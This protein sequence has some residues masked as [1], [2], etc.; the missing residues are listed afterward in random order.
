MAIAKRFALHSNEKTWYA[1]PTNAAHAFSTNN[2][3][4]KVYKTSL[5][6]NL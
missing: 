4:G 5:F 2:L 1:K 3:S 6:V